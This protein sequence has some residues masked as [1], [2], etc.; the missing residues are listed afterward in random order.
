MTT[1]T[2]RVEDIHCGGCENAIRKALTRLGGVRDVAPDSATN[3][4]R[5]DFDSSQT[6]T[7]AIAERLAAAGYPVIE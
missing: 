2:F 5:V 3:Q 6:S 1:Q 7:A 4:V